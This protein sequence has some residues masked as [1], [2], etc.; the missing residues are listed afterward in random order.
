MGVYLVNIGLRMVCIQSGSLAMSMH[1]VDRGL[2]VS[3]Y[4]VRVSSSGYRILHVCSHLIPSGN[5]K[6]ISLCDVVKL[7]VDGN[8]QIPRNVVELCKKYYKVHVHAYIQL[9]FLHNMGMW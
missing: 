5:T 8:F 1:P 2:G 9:L 3:M 7:A 4:P 6:L